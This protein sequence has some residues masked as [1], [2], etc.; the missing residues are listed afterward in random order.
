MIS[1]SL[2]TCHDV[3]WFPCRSYDPVAP[4][5]HEWTYESMIYD[6]L[7]TDGPTYLWVCAAAKQQSTGACTLFWSSLESEIL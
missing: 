7:K 5:I 3:S 1:P 6:L 4:F 2:V